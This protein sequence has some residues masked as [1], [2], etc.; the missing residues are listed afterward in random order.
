M[1]FYDALV[2]KWATLTPGTTAQ[3]LAEIRAAV[4]TVSVPAIAMVVPTY[5][6]YN[7]IDA[8][9]FGALSATLQQHVRDILGMGTVDASPG[10]AVRA[11]IS[12]IF[13]G[14]AG[15]NTRAALTAL[16]V[17]FDTPTQSTPWWQT[18]GYTHNVTLDDLVLAGGLV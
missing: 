12:S 8:S 4:V 17:T 2:A 13:A 10:T 11:R 15:P 5:Q 14:A 7:L 9:E 16:A 1:A 3:K 6:I 18:V